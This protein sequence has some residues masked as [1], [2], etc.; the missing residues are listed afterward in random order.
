[1]CVCVCVCVL[2]FPRVD[3]YKTLCHEVSRSLLTSSHSTL[4]CLLVWRLFR[5]YLCN[6]IVGVGN[7]QFVLLCI[8]CR[9]VRM[10]F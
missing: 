3:D 4:L 5:V 6:M 1:M 10:C 2:V 8:T 7:Y 9:V